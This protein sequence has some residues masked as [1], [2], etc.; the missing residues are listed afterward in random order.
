[1]SYIIKTY[2]GDKPLY[3]YKLCRK[4]YQQDGTPAFREDLVDAY[5]FSRKDEAYHVMGEIAKNYPEVH[6]ELEEI[7]EKGTLRDSDGYVPLE[8]TV[9]AM[10]S[11]NPAER[12][13][14]EY[15]QL[16]TRRHKLKE[17]RKTIELDAGPIELE[18]IDEQIA[19]MHSYMIDL[20]TRCEYKKID[21]TKAEKGIA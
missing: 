19:H 17:Y 8:K 2:D 20:L 7:P 18:M 11:G 3:F 9:E 5:V 13:W 6:L 4:V 10:L 21:L 15:E 16:N 1:M 14:A 12:I